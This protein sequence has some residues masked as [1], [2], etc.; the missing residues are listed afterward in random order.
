LLTESIFLGILGAVAGLA[1]GNALMRGMKLWAPPDMLP[2]QADV[3]MDY[4]VLL[5]T[6][7][8]GILTGILFG[9]AP[10]LSGTRPD[11]AGSLKESGRTTAG[12]APRLLP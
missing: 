9:L 5:F 4:G 10:A 2:P 11:L 12:P 7:V 1:L 3:R 8:I 6:T